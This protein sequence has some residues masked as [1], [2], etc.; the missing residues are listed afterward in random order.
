[1][2]TR[3]RFDSEDKTWNRICLIRIEGGLHGT[4]DGA[5]VDILASEDKTLT[6]IQQ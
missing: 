1:M 3:G 6:R 5:F 2:F 4:S